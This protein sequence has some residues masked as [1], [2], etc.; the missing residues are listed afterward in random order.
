MNYTRMRN[1]TKLF[2]IVLLLIIGLNHGYSQ[3]PKSSLLWKVSGNGLS[4]PSYLF[5]TIHALPSDKF[6]LSD[7]F[8][9]RFD[10]TE[11][12]VLEIDMSNPQMMGELQNEMVMKTQKID[13]LLSKEDFQIVSSFFKDSLAIPLLMVSRVKPIF[14][15]SFILQKY[16]GNNPA[17]YEITFLKMAQSSKKQVLGLET[18]KEQISYIDK[19][20]LKDQATMLVESVKEYNEQKKEY[21]Q[22]VEVYLTGDMDKICQVMIETTKEYKVFGN[23]L[24]DDRNKKWAELIPPMVQKSSCF[25]A[26]GSGHLGGKNGVINLLRAKGYS[27][28]PVH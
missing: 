5:G 3:K 15:A 24:I 27:V 10:E 20:S 11:K 2:T 21:F 25:I 28:E 6:F 7:T 1:L 23:I 16:L 14:L 13:S 22:L 9:A 12:L 26:V 19:I 18:I 4:R 17:S 8:K